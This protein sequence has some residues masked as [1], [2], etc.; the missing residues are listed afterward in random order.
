MDLLQERYLMKKTHKSEKIMTFISNNVGLVGLL[1]IINFLLIYFLFN[2]LQTT[3]L[4]LKMLES[5]SNS[6]VNEMNNLSKPIL[7]EETAPKKK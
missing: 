6:V 3:E 4:R 1:T 7:E 2:R 5:T